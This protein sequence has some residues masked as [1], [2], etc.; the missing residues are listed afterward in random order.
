MDIL[1]VLDNIHNNTSR[2]TSKYMYVEIYNMSISTKKG[3]RHWYR[4]SVALENCCI[5][6]G[7]YYEIVEHNN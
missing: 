1:S 4:Y 3:C 2:F 7:I 5:L 6:N